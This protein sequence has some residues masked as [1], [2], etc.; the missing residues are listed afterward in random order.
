MAS[1]NTVQVQVRI[2]RDTK[3][4]SIRDALYFDKSDFFNADGS[5]KVTSAQIDTLAA[6]RVV[7]YEK[8]VED[9]QLVIPNVPTVDELFDQFKDKLRRLKA[10]IKKK[11]E[12]G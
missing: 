6:A 11:E 2:E 8:A 1:T 9:A 12:G 7:T 3:Y 10:W 5:Q 4:G